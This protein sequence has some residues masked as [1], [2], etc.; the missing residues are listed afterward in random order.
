MTEPQAD[1]PEGGTEYGH[2]AGLVSRAAAWMLDLFVLLAGLYGSIL[3]AST[4]QSIFSL[5]PPSVP[6]ISRVA[7]IVTFGAGAF[8]YLFVGWS[9]WGK[10][11]GKAVLGLEVLRADGS[12]LPA[13]RCIIRIFGYVVSA[14]L[15]GMGYW[16]VALSPRRRAWH[17]AMAGSCVV[18]AWRARSSRIFDALGQGQGTGRRRRRAGPDGSGADSAPVR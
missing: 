8:V 4:V 6:Q 9:V 1:R 17:D 2:Y 5:E 13:L 12:K 18:Y 15:F 7:F 10:T 16:W 3:V 11:I 14:L